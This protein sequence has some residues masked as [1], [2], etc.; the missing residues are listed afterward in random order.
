VIK[1]LNRNSEEGQIVAVFTEKNNTVSEIKKG[2][3]S[4]KR[5]IG[6]SE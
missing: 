3:F 5:I 4:R 2:H 6:Y 1:F